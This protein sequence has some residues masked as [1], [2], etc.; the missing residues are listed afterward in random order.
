[1]KAPD[2]RWT[3]EGVKRADEERN[4]SAFIIRYRLIDAKLH[5]RSFIYR[6]S[7]VL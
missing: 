4:L 6:A 5:A 1:M 2:G 7:Y 3:V